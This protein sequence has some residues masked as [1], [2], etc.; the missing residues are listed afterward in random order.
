[1]GNQAKPIS[2]PSVQTRTAIG[3]FGAQEEAEIKLG[4]SENVFRPIGASEQVEQ[5][6]TAHGHHFQQGSFSPL[7]RSTSMC[8]VLRACG[9]EIEQSDLAP[10]VLVTHQY[11][12]ANQESNPHAALMRA[13]TLYITRIQPLLL[14]ASTQAPLRIMSFLCS[15]PKAKILDTY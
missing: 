7:G 6:Q 15:I 12:F 14:Q 11:A 2:S 5:W 1:M 8:D 13:Y 3:R 10:Y 9:K 4:I